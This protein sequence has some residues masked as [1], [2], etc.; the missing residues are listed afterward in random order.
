MSKNFYLIL[1]LLYLYRYL[2]EYITDYMMNFKGAFT[3]MSIYFQIV[4][5]VIKC[6]IVY[7]VIKNI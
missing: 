2:S 3:S 1:V 7:H 4:L 5:T 6:L